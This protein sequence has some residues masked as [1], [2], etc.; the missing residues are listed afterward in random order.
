MLSAKEAG[1]GLQDW[2]QLL[3]RS[4]MAS[5]EHL[6]FL[7]HKVNWFAAPFSTYHQQLMQVLRIYKSRSRQ[8]AKVAHNLVI[9]SLT[10]RS[11][12][13]QALSCLVQLFQESYDKRGIIECLRDN[14]P[15]KL[16]PL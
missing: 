14:Y 5:P 7:I 10:V 11:S 12:H 8:A 9:E 3:I 16:C 6:D 15:H 4:S 13:S 2:L 1:A